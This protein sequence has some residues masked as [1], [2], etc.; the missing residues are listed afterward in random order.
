MKF[1]FLLNNV[2]IDEPIGFDG[3]KPVIER[4]D[5]HGM[6]VSVSLSKIGFYGK[7]LKII[8]DAY[9]TDIDTELP[10]IVQVLLDKWKNI[11]SGVVDLSSYERLTENGACRINCNVGEI[12]I[13]TIFNNRYDTKVELS[14]LTSLDDDNLPEY[15]MLKR[16][17]SFPSKEIILTSGANFDEDTKSDLM[18]IYTGSGNYDKDFIIPF[19]DP[20]SNEI[21]M[22]NSR[23]TLSEMTTV[24]PASDDFCFI[25][26]KDTNP[27]LKS[28]CN[29]NLDIRVKFTIT[30]TFPA[31]TNQ[32]RLFI[33]HSYANTGY[34]KE[35]LL[36]KELVVENTGPDGYFKTIN[37]DVSFTT[38]KDNPISMEYDEGIVVRLLLNNISSTG[39]SYLTMVYTAKKESKISITALSRSKESYH[40]I[41]LVH[42]S[43][44]RLSEIISGKLPDAYGLTV[45]SD[46]YARVNSDVN[47]RNGF[48]GGSLKAL[49]N[50]YELRN[51]DLTSGERPPIK[52]SFKDLFES[53]NAIDNIG[54]GFWEDENGM[55]YLRV[56][57]WQW[58]YKDS[59][60]MEIKNPNN[61]KRSIRADKVYTGLKIGYSKYLDEQEINAIDTFHTD[62][63]YYT[64]LKAVDNKLEK[65]C[66]FIA[67]PYAIE[68]TRRKQFHKD[69]SNWKYDE[70]VFVVA[71]RYTSALD[72]VNDFF[73]DEG[74]KNTKDFEGNDTVISPNTMFNVRISPKR[75]AIRWSERY[76]EAISNKNSLNYTA[77]TGNVAAEGNPKLLSDSSDGL[78]VFGSHSYLEDSASG[79]II[80]ERDNIG[81][82]APVLKP[83]ILSFDYPITFDQ[84]AAIMANPYGKII[85]D[86]EECYIQKV[87][88][89]LIERKASF[90][91]IPKNV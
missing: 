43:L 9:N 69:T 33:L 90:E 36:A 87:T 84:Y 85:V 54:W 37:A 82:K 20:Y 73:I 2:E 16:N 50:G 76:F 52:L 61:V 29:F 88:P 91:L 22:F 51:Q 14:R 71:L 45:K 78:P 55:L 1:R 12:G 13:K 44:S 19:G 48:G 64:G 10:F 70:D 21:N 89:S 53:L 60:I 8:E 86:G 15:G 7:A 56:E 25:F 34:G 35:A 24:T 65:M 5:H 81:W 17:I 11:Y 74:M 63:E 23:Q 68:V 6:S 46:W 38:D 4:T 32:A 26:D 79:Q 75:N 72:F 30:G 41:S 58:F 57:R 18:S 39:L 83:E 42:E 77:G 59:F 31:Q 67:D 27:D 28:P 62:R 40:N 66:K 49:L 3:F 47:Q 80:S